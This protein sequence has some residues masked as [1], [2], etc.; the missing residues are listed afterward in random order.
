[1]PFKFDLSISLTDLLAT[2][3]WAP[4]GLLQQLYDYKILLQMLKIIANVHQCQV[5]Q[6][7]YNQG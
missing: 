1:M 3:L 7:Y 2:V 6:A 5:S 4:S